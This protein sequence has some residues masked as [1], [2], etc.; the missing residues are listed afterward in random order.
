M[1]KIFTLL[2]FVAVLSLQSCTVSEEVYVDNTPRTEVFEVPTSFVAANNYSKQIV[3][4]PNIYSSDE[5]LVYRLSGSNVWE[6]LPESHYFNDGSFDFGYEFD[7][8]NRDVTVYLT[9]SN[10][11]TVPTNFRLDQIL[12][13]VIIPDSFAKSINK[14]NYVDVVTALNL[15]DDQIKTINF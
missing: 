13:V 4:N 1:K 12:R 6:L 8:T 7:Y 5:V 11:K 15:K 9:G 14:K 3:F 10:L 2:A